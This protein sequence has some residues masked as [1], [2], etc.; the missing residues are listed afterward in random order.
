MAQK[1]PSYLWRSRHGIYYFRWVVPPSLQSK[2][3]G[4]R[5]IRR[6]LHT[7]RRKQ[8]L[9]LA[10]AHM[11]AVDNEVLQMGD[12][13][14]GQEELSVGW[15][16]ALIPVGNTY[17]PISIDHGD[18][19]QER[20]TLNTALNALVTST[21]AECAAP[22]PSPALSVAIEL[23]CE[24]YTKAKNWTLKTAEEVRAL[25]AELIE[26]IGDKPVSEISY[27]DG[28][29]YKA[30]L[31]K[32]PANRKKKPAYRDMT[33]ADLA[34]LATVQ[35]MSI[36]SVN[37]RLT[38]VSSLFQWLTRQNYVQNN[39]FAGMNIKRKKQAKTS[40]RPAF[41]DEELTALFDRERYA[42]LRK[43][44]QYWVPLIG[45][46][47][48]MRLNEIAQLH[49][50]DFQLDGNQWAFSVNDKGS[51]KR[52]KTPSSIRLVPIH[53]RLVELG[54]LDY[55]AELE[56]R[57][58]TRLFPDLNKRRDGYGQTV[59]NWYARYMKKCGVT[60]S[61]KVF[62]TLRH[63]F[64]NHLKQLG[65]DQSRVAAILGH[66]EEGITFSTYANPYAPALL[67]K[68][69]ERFDVRVDVEAYKKV[70]AMPHRLEK[71]KR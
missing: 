41:T 68:T 53:P 54:L 66:A 45:L 71:D 43:P 37:K 40:Q 34:S 11:H 4:R 50:D 49:L 19:A 48:G 25:F 61:G 30:A 23:Y 7:A 38:R 27:E 20:E 16:T 10:R 57:G 39:P 59:S 65:V 6:S 1:A 32:L 69:V 17:I 24:E 2:F 28:R 13:R 47:S 22:T 31:L 67:A 58:F 14:K 52:V 8:A 60:A 42:E 56:A 15:I 62:H 44:Y 12:R 5:E 64:S 46:Y 33:I 63:T 36:T 26:I 55:R 51:D 35:P 18:P 3:D 29:A 21:S 70:I 9:V